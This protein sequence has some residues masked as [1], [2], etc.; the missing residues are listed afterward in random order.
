MSLNARMT[1]L[2][3]L[4]LAA[5]LATWLI[6][7]RL[8]Q[9]RAEE[10]H[11]EA[12]RA[13]TQS[14]AQ[15]LN[16]TGEPARR[17]VR[18]FSDWPDFQSWLAT[19]TPDWAESNLAPA[20]AHYDLH[21]LWVLSTEG[22]LIHSTQRHPVPP[23]PPPTL[24]QA[25]PLEPGQHFFADSR[26]GLLELWAERIS[27]TPGG[28]LIVSRAWDQ[29]FLSMLGRLTEFRVQLLPATDSSVPPP[30]GLLVRMP[31][32][33]AD[34]RPLRLLQA[35]LPRPDFTA[36][37]AEDT[38]AIR[39]LLAFGLLV[40]IAVSIA[41]GQWVL[42]PLQLIGQSLARD[43][44]APVVALQHDR[45]EF[46]RL[47]AL[48]TQSFR[49]R[50]ALQRENEER[51][52]TE[53][54]LRASEEQ[55]R[56]SLELRARLAR[57]LHDGVIQ[58]IYA[59]GLGLES[60]LSE[61]GHDDASA[62]HRL[63]HCR[64][65]LNG[66][67]RE[68]RAFISGLEPEQLERHGFAQELAALTR[69]MQALW[70]ARIVHRTD[71]QAARRLTVGQEVHA[72]QIVREC[73]SNALRHGG[74]RRILITLARDGRQARLAIRDDGRGFDPTQVGNLGSGLGNLATRAREMHGT[75]QLDSRPGQGVAVTVTFPLV[76]SNP[77]VS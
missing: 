29:R 15:W 44:P 65:S 37:L 21:A 38:Q 59:A 67:I 45:G 64:Q 53:Q 10:M 17:V 73:I 3:G 62:R 8:Q 47:A 54:A 66:V 18:D 25:K 4:L 68:V 28:W 2:L 41:I 36:F 32:A 71:P 6:V 11:G 56:R 70:S 1:I 72:L 14:L 12:V 77:S 26:D 7:R 74:A 27:G 39:L 75:L 52:R 35:E 24:P 5:F 30:G 13:A 57:D 76:D 61:L 19:L 63:T 46:G 69:T 9:D 34:G 22:R 60:A 31:L 42:R 16:L 49:Q 23:L 40:V 51:Q 33:A 55:V 48:V 20:L 43:D 58:S 50:Q